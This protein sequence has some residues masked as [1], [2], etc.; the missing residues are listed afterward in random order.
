[1]KLVLYTHACASIHRVACAIAA[2]RTLAEC[3]Y[4]LSHTAQSQTL[5]H[6]CALAVGSAVCV[7]VQFRPIAD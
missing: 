1:M 2:G 3:V 7:Q 5:V 4:A 6:V